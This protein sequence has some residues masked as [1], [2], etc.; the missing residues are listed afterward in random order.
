MKKEEL[1][2]KQA[3]KGVEKKEVNDSQKEEQEKENEMKELD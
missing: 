2:G 3:L 1:G